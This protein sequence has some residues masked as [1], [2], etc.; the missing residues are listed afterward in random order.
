MTDTMPDEVAEAARQEEEAEAALAGAQGDVPA[1]VDYFAAAETYIVTLPD[2]VSKLTCQVF[3]EGMR[4]KYQKAGNKEVRIHR[5][6]RD[7]YFKISSAEEREALLESAIVGWNLQ[8][9]H[10]GEMVE[11]PFNQSTLKDFLQKAPPSVI[12]HIEKEVRKQET[13]LLDD[14]TVEDIDKQ[15]E[16][17]QELRSEVEA[18]EEGKD[19]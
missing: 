11:K 13:W 2:G 6:S 19:S 4:K 3:N 14:M 18:R 16:E 8:S 12:D 17:L 7:A 9:M 5:A 15:I 10:R 1:P